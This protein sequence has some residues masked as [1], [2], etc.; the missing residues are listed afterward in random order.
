VTPSRLDHV[1]RDQLQDNVQFPKV[2]MAWH[3]P[4]LYAPGDAEMDLASVILNEGKA[5][6]LFKA[7]VYDHELAQDIQ[8]M[9]SS[10]D[11]GSYFEVDAIAR[12]DV[13]LAQLEAA[14]DA[15]LTK[16]VKEPLSPDELTRAK[17]QLETRYVQRLESLAERAMLLNSYQAT[18]GDPNYAEKDLQRYRDVTATSFQQAV[19]STLNLDAR[20]ILHIVPKPE[21]TPSGQPAQGGAQ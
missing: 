15:E 12:P 6:R 19:R 13:S 18:R 17:N 4:N 8:V 2:V 20:V 5:S 3:S 11:A 14:I 7:L 16:L 21:Q 9:Q 10:R 1:V